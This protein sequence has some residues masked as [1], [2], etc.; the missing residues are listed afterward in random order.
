MKQLL[1]YE[2]VQPLRYVDHGN[3]SVRPLSDFRFAAEINSV[4]V[5]AAEFSAAAQDM[6]IVF[7][8]TETEVLPAVLLGVEDSS[9]LFIGEDGRWNG[10]Y[11]PAFL[12]RY[13]FVFAQNEGSDQLSLCIDE[14][15]NALNTDGVGERL[16]D[17]EGSRT[18]YLNQMLD[19]AAQYQTQFLRTR[20]FCQRLKELSLLEPAALSVREGSEARGMGGFFRVS[21]D[22]LKAMPRQA[23]Y[24]M[25]EADELELCFLH[26][27]SLSNVGG[28]SRRRAER[29]LA[30]T[31][32]QVAH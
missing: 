15:C 18:S 28:L 20:V 13:P 11:I 24:E 7:A 14:A 4:P 30:K 3:V 17:S 29:S 5:V 6:V 8:G 25:F 19:F 21:R 22:R 10:T 32:T 2:R 9:N 12:R 16:F 23:L 26:M 27:Q 31:D 1:L